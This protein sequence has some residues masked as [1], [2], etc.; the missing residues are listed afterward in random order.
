[1]LI[2]KQANVVLFEDEPFYVDKVRKVLA[3]TSHRLVEIA[4]TLEASLDL[5]V[6]IKE[7]KLQTAE[8]IDAV[9]LDGNLSDDL[10]RNGSDA[11][12]IAQKL[13]ELGLV[14]SEWVYRPKNH[15]VFKRLYTRRLWSSGPP[16][17]R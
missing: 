6:R 10:E 2:M 12:T 7:R 11:I 3:P 4:S 16:R 1:M 15:R 5:L 9:I 8:V 13:G 17:S 14:F